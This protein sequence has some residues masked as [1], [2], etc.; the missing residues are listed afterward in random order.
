VLRIASAPARDGTVQATISDS[1]PGIAFQRLD[2]VF[3][4]F[5]TTKSTGLGL[6]LAICRTIV[7]AHGGRIWV[8]N[9]DVAG[10]TF[11]TEFP[12]LR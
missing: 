12:A 9:G 6:G 7:D 1:G 8:E 10:A 2:H 11:F 4:P 3:E 5:V